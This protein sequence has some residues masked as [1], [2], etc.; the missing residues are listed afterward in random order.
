MQVHW[1]WNGAEEDLREKS[2]ENEACSVRGKEYW[3]FFVL[4]TL[5]IYLMLSRPRR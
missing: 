3:S 2:M 4:V 5:S 1:Q